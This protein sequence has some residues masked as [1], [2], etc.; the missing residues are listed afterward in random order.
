VH[1]EGLHSHDGLTTALVDC[2]VL[3][4]RGLGPR[5]V[6]DLSAR[7]I[8]AIVCSVERAD[9]AARLFAQGTLPRSTGTGCGHHQ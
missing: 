9:D 1:Q 8:E 2:R 7:G 5:L 4:T 6:A 3:I